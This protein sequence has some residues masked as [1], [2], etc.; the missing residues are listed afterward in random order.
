[1]NEGGKVI[2]QYNTTADLITDNF[3]PDSMSISRDRVTDETAEV[4]ILKPEHPIF[5]TPNKITVADFN[6]WIQE[7][8]LYFPNKYSA[9]YE[10]ILS[11]NDPKEKH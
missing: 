6:N 10:E 3:V 7:R 11:M 2:F 4:R 1:M 5:S 8:G 9:S